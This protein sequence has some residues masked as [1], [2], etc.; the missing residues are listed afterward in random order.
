[1]ARHQSRQ[2]VLALISGLSDRA[3][4]PV[5][6]FCEREH[7]PCLLPSAPGVDPLQPSDWSFHFTRGV[8]LEAALIAGDLAGPSAPSAV[9]G[10]LFQLVDGSEVAALGARVL[11][12]RLNAPLSG[13]RTLPAS[14]AA[15]VVAGLRR[16]DHLVL[17]LSAPVLASL[18]ARLAL[19][20]GVSLHVSGELGGLDDLPLPRP[21]RDAARVSYTYQPADRRIGRQILNAGALLRAQGD[22]LQPDLVLLQGNAYSACEMG[23]RALRMMG[24]RVSRTRLLELFEASDESALAVGFPRFTLGPGQRVGSRGGYLMRF[25]S[26]RPGRLLPVGDWQVPD[27]SDIPDAKP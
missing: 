22:A 4:Q 19:P 21:W 16:G 10:R 14:H 23:T 1:L 18:P 15:A 9:R 27:W 5:Q 11:A 8:A 20:A 25:D 2:P 7:M 6:A 3:W 13:R 17:W 26:E 12:Q 24:Q